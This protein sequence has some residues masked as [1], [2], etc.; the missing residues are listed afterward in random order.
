MKK[1][2]QSKF[3]SINVISFLLAAG[4]PFFNS[5]K[6]G[7]HAIGNAEQITGLALLIYFFLGPRFIHLNPGRARSTSFAQ[8]YYI[9]TGLI[10]ASL[11]FGGEVHEGSFLQFFYFLELAVLF[12]LFSEMLFDESTIKSLCY[13]LLAGFAACV[14]IAVMQ[15]LKVEKFN[16]FK[17]EDLN[18]NTSYDG[19]ATSDILRVWGPFG[20]A[21]TFSFYLS[22]AGCMLFTYFRYVQK[23][24]LIS[25][26]IYG[27]TLL[28]IGLTISRMALFGFI[29][30]TGIVH[31]MSLSRKKRAV[32]AFSIL[33]IGAIGF[34]LMTAL[35][36]QNP[37]IS[38][39]SESG[40]DFKGGRLA[41]WEVGYRVWTDNI[42]F[43]TGPGNLNAALYKAGW[44]RGGM[45][46]LVISNW[47]GHVES[48]YL[49]ML[50]TFGALP[51]IF[52]L[53]YLA[54]YLRS[55]FALMKAGFRNSELALGIPFFG[56][57][58]CFVFSNLVNPAMNFEFRLPLL[59]V[60]IMALCNNLY[61]RYFLSPLAVAA[62]QS[63]IGV[64]TV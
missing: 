19:D 58:L 40:D 11:V 17:E 1:S 13:G 23:K 50:F 5:F 10:F 53:L 59:M 31:Y 12:F 8:Y 46:R 54:G 24:K 38:R 48:Y 51:F 27:M 61:K 34:G 16:L 3:K 2:A 62:P 20:N 25:W 28:G 35:Y 39:L 26:A 41:L 42:L 15:F 43:G 9:F 6:M 18:V 55:S 60:I 44:T 49:T 52:Y 57:Y 4:L 36:S 7:S 32:F 63:S 47:A 45:D 30:C 22:V 33:V 21:L 56:T 29:A 14:F 64:F 37:I